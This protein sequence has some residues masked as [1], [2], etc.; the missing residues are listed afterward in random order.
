MPE[1]FS[2]GSGGWLKM[3]F[4]QAFCRSWRNLH[5]RLGNQKLPFKHFGAAEGP[6]LS[7]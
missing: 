6:D 3:R 2:T 4:Y 7:G 1:V 5:D